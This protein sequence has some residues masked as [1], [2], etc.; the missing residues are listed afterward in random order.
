MIPRNCFFAVLGFLLIAPAVSAEIPDHVWSQRFGDSSVQEG[1]SVVVDA[2][3]NVIVAGNFKGTVDFGGGTLT[4]AGDYDI[5]VLKF[6]ATGNHVW[7][8]RFG[9][10]SRQIGMSVAVDEF[11]N[12]LVT[13]HFKGTVDFGGGSLTSSYYEDIFLVKFD[14]GGG[15]IWSKRFGTPYEQFGESVVVDG[16]GNVIFTGAFADTV[17]FGG[18]PLA[19]AGGHDVIVAKFDAS[20]GHLWSNRFGDL[21]T[22]FG[23]DVAADA[24]GSVIVTGYYA[25]DLDFGGG[26]LPSAPFPDINC[27]IAKLD[28]SGSH[29]WSEGFGDST[30]RQT[31]STV[32][33]DASGN[34]YFTGHFNGTADLGGGPLTSYHMSDIVIAKFDPNG[35]HIWSQIF[36]GF[37]SQVPYSAAVDVSGNL[38]VTGQIRGTVDFGG[39]PLS[40]LGDAWEDIFVAKFDGS[41]S[42]VW[43]RRY[44]A[45]GPQRGRG[46]AVDG[47]G[48]VIVTG[49][50]KTTVDFGG[51]L[52]TSAGDR[53]IFIAKFR[54]GAC[55]LVL[56]PEDTLIEAFSTIDALVLDG[57]TIANTESSPLTFN[58][59]VTTPGP[60]ILMDNGDP[61]SLAGTTP[62]LPPCGS[63]SPPDAALEVPAITS[64][65]VQPVTYHVSCVEDPS[66]VDSCVTL[67]V[68]DAPVA[69]VISSFVVD[70]IDGGVRLIWEVFSDDEVQGYR[71]YRAMESNSSAELVNPE[72]LIP[73]ETR[74]FVDDGVRYGRAYDYT[75]GVVQEDGSEIRSQIATVNLNAPSFV[76]YQNIP[77]PFNPATTIRFDVPVGGAHTTLAVYD[78]SGRLVRVL[79]D[80]HMAEGTYREDWDGSDANGNA[81]AS[82]VYFYRLDA[83]A[84]VRTRKMVILK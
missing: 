27:F 14:A 54:P 8:K 73:P 12:V 61:A 62:L 48:N 31:A 49:D 35:N 69:A 6:D 50:F 41:G 37:E 56:C 24:S 55:A 40:P 59:H 29:L 80:K 45:S 81:V 33:V 13:G 34:A 20:G 32:D 4:S 36:A 53:D 58:Y 1:S 38:I 44:G 72:G 19:S 16:L 9:D 46:A 66:L 11:G 82:G 22:D 43:S 17:D 39:G 30:D 3:G 25:G 67:V 64:Y 71:I 26:P 52:L 60:A 68:F 2:S 84:F 5:F 63:L 47:S 42:H 83:P 70:A 23:Y 65:T 77:N 79:V 21:K 51:S 78:V 15:H 18:G 75:L 57:F 74:M 28:A 76:L 7:S 10:S